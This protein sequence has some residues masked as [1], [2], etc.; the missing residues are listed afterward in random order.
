[1]RGRLVLL[2]GFG[3][4]YVQ[5]KGYASE[6]ASKVSGAVKERRTDPRSSLQ[7]APPPT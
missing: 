6:G 1:M 5:A 2:M 7:V 3:A 4:G